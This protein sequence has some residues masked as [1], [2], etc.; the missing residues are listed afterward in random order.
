MTSVTPHAP[1]RRVEHLTRT[2]TQSAPGPWLALPRRLAARADLRHGTWSGDK[3]Y[4]DDIKCR[5]LVIRANCQS[6]EVYL[7]T[8]PVVPMEDAG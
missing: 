3:V 1:Y 6:A 2:M 8:Q 7:R 4:R 5:C